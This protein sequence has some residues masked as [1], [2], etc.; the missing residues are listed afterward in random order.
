MQETS[1]L[2]SKET[3]DP[4]VKRNIKILKITFIT[5]NLERS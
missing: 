5:P 2:V 4:E 3:E 1:K